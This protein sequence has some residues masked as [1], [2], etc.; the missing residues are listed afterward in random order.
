MPTAFNKYQYTFSSKCHRAQVDWR[1]TAILTLIMLQWTNIFAQDKATSSNPKLRVVSYNVENLYDTVDDPLTDDSEFLPHGAIQWTDTKYKQKLSTIA[2]VISSIGEWGFPALIGLVEIENSDVIKDLVTHPKLAR[3]DYKQVVSYAADPRGVD[4]ALLWHP[5][6]FKMVDA[7]EIPHYGSTLYYPYLR[8]QRSAMQRSGSGRNTLWVTLEEKTTGL[9]FDVFVVHLP[10]RRG[11][12]NSTSSKR[13]KVTEKIAQIISSV[14]KL[15][16]DARII[17]MGDFNDSPSDKAVKNGFST[18]MLNGKDTLIPN[19]L[20]NLGGPLE[21]QGKGTHYFARKMWLP[22]QFIV[23]GTL[24]DPEQPISIQ[25]GG[26][27]IYSPPNMQIDGRPRRSFRGMRYTGGFS[28]H[29]PI[30]LD[31]VILKKVNEN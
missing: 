7:K 4:V 3:Q 16:K 26:M 5:K 17:V 6:H 13:V 21:R 31:L 12:V 18:S 14:Q 20:Y 27:K 15:R 8:D 9:Y 29:Y 28:D 2:G 23:S 10:S 24:L 11:G 1:C 30:Y 22:D 25:S 19:A